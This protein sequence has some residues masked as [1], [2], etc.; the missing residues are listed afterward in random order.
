MAANPSLKYLTE[1]PITFYAILNSE[2]NND[3]ELFGFE[4]ISDSSG[5]IELTVKLNLN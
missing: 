3:A 5:S 4:I 2:F 1:I